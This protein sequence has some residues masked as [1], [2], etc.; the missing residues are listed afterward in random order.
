MTL[1]EVIKEIESVAKE[2]PSVNMIVRN[3]V[4]R[5]NAAPELKYGV[6]AWLQREH[7]YSAETDSY[8]FSFT[9]FYVDRLTE[10]GSNEVEIQSTGITTLTNMI[11]ALESRGVDIYDDYTFQSFNQRFMDVCAGVFSNVTFIVSAD[12]TCDEGYPDFG[13][14]DFSDDFLIY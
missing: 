14:S 10:D 13:G 12:N 5:I 4:F 11:K 2:Q 1:A 7:R 6:F 9:F 8:L 3:D